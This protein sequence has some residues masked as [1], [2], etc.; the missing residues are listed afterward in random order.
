MKYIN[1]CSFLFVGS[2]THRPASS[3]HCVRPLRL[4][5]R[6]GSVPVPQ[7]SAEVH[8]N[9]RTEGKSERFF[10]LGGFN[11]IAPKSVLCLY[12][13]FMAMC[14]VG[15]PQSFTRGDRGA[16]GC[17]LR[18]GCH[19]E[20]YHGGQRTVFHRWAGGGGGEEEQV[21]QIDNSSSFSS[22]PYFNSRC[23]TLHSFV[24][25]TIICCI[26]NTLQLWIFIII[27]SQKWIAKM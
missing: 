10:F 3:H 15:E 1:E 2:Q 18:R 14:F 25:K 7:Q 4:C 27:N 12:W 5:A 21:E 16:V 26:Y 23:Y 11:V 13:E 9:L 17:G 8:R 22:S 20:P 19:Q 24:V 6:P